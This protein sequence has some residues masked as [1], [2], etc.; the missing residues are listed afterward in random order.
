M[1]QHGELGE[2]HIEDR[3]IKQGVQSEGARADG[4]LCYF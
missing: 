3:S 4:Y 2:F 1:K